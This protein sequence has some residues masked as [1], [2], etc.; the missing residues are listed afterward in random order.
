MSIGTIY[1]LLLKGLFAVK[2]S[3]FE[4]LLVAANNQTEPQC[5]LFVFASAEL[6]SGHTESQK[7]QFEERKGGALTPVMCVDKLPSELSNFA[8]LVE[9][10]RQTGKSW[11]IVFVAGMSVKPGT[12]PNSDEVE[13]P[14][15]AMVEDIKK[16]KISNFLAF[17]QE[18]ELVQLR[19]F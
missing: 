7:N 8:G 14:L 3:S 1:Y 10:S 5:L 16:G 9:E 11:D 2:I 13:K 12:K 15:K 17:S 19:T 4:D 6:P 18:G